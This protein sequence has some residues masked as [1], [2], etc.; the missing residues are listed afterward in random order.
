[1]VKRHSCKV[2]NSVRFRA[3]DL[4]T[5]VKSGSSSGSNPDDPAFGIVPMAANM[6]RYAW[7]TVTELDE[8]VAFS[9][10]DATRRWVCLMTTQ[11]EYLLL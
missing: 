1:M 10:V 5:E 9:V 7:I 11:K 3:R 8:F 4:Y 6:L 2:G